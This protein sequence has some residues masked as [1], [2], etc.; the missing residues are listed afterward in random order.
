[1]GGLFH[2]KCGALFKG[3]DVSRQVQEAWVNKLNP[4]HVISFVLFLVL[5]A[6]LPI[7]RRAGPP[8]LVAIGLF[9]AIMLWREGRL[10][11]SFKSH[12]RKP[13]T[14]L[15]ATFMAWAIISLGWSTD[16]SRGGVYIATALILVASF[17]MISEFPLAKSAPVFLVAGLSLGSI[18][19]AFDLSS[20]SHAL[21]WI[22][23]TDPGAWRYNM[24]AVSYSVFSM[25]LLSHYDALR[26][27][28]MVAVLMLVAI[29]TFLGESETAKLVLALFPI[30]F[31]VIIVTP[32]SIIKPA[33]TSVLAFIII[34]SAAGM[35]G[36]I[37]LKHLVPP[38]F[39]LQGSGDARLAIW[40]GAADFA[41]HGLPFGW[42]VATTA[43]PYG[44]AYFLA[45]SQEVQWAI[46]HWHPHDNFLQVAA[47][48]GLPG[49]ATGLNMLAIII[50][51]GFPA[52]RIQFAA[53]VTFVMV[54][55]GIASIS[56]GFW[57]SWWWADVLIGW[58][59]V[60][61]AAAIHEKQSL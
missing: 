4:S 36:L 44:T 39:W 10:G 1:M 45:A 12:L 48:L 59:I 56:H 18:F 19:M 40:S 30:L 2:P 33:V 22:H 26:L 5:P 37:I 35:P 58:Y 41:N 29:A 24:V 6:I 53:Y 51:K 3:H 32:R 50:I 43:S 34:Y 47:E 54:I 46:S 55:I 9:A 57:Q 13:A 61:G 8:T 25:A 31:L 21:K 17:L 16:P 38:E 42:G 15:F 23:T 52:S 7:I 11:Q 27:L 28:R 14:I 20:G 60:A 49:L